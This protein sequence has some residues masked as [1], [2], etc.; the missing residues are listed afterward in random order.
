MLARTQRFVKV[1][2]L[3]I[4]FDLFKYCCVLDGK[5]YILKYRIEFSMSKDIRGALR[6]RGLQRLRKIRRKDPNK[7]RLEDFEYID[8][9]DLNEREFKLFRDMLF[10]K[11]HGRGGIH[12]SVHSL[13]VSDSAG[14]TWEI[15][16]W[17]GKVDTRDYNVF[18]AGNKVVGFILYEDAHQK[19]K[20]EIYFDRKELSED[21]SKIIKYVRARYDVKM[22]QERFYRSGFNVEK[23]NRRR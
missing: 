7:W 3:Q 23:S 1:I 16:E 11:L 4:D 19:R 22:L 9:Y 13:Y 12:Q 17:F 10:P 6:L 8:I 14:K 20:M 21:W 5:I 2:L 18:V 15:G